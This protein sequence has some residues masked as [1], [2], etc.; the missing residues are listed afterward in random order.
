MAQSAANASNGAT[1]TQAAAGALS[2]M[3][4]ELM[5]LVAQY[6]F[7]GGDGP[8][9]GGRGA[10]TAVA[11]RASGTGVEA[12]SVRDQ[13]KQAVGAHAMWKARLRDAIATGTSDVS[14][15]QSGRDDACKFGQWLGSLSPELARSTHATEV[16][17]LHATFHREASKVLALALDGRAADARTAMQQGA[18]F[19]SVSAELTQAMTNWAAQS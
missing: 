15:A 4:S 3:A 18:P 14:V 8:G 16:R 5:G 12:E 2:G 10:A 17:A 19:A 13:I 6:T 1:D 11:E 9:G 7:N